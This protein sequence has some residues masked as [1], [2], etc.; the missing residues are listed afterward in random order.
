MIT[1]LIEEISHLAIPPHINVPP[2]SSIGHEM[3]Q[4]VGAPTRLYD[5]LAGST[6]QFCRGAD[7]CVIAVERT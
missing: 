4:T 6:D 7:G 2:S 5:T 1:F 3:E